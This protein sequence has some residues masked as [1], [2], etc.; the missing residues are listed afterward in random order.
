MIFN[1]STIQAYGKGNDDQKTMYVLDSKSVA[2]RRNL[3]PFNLGY[4]YYTMVDGGDN[5]YG[6]YFNQNTYRLVIS[7]NLMCLATKNNLDEPVTK[8]AD[9][10]MRVTYTIQEEE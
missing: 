9:M 2:R 3:A 7:Y 8:T 1:K 6:F 10:T 5:A 4:H